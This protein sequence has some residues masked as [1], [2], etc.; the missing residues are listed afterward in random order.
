MKIAYN[1]A[2]A[3]KSFYSQRQDIEEKAKSGKM[4]KNGG[5]KNKTAAGL[6]LAASIAGAVI[7]LAVYN[8]RHGKLNKMK[9]VFTRSESTVKDKITVSSGIIDVEN[10]KQIGISVTG[11]ILG[12]LAAGFATDKNKENRKSKVQEGV[13][14]FLNCMIPMGIITAADTIIKR[15]EIKTGILGKTALIAGGI[16]SGMFLSNKVAN[17]VNKA[18]FNKGKEDGFEK[19]KMKPTDCLVHAD[20]VLGVLVMSKVPYVKEFGKLLPL[21]YSH[22]GYETGTKQKQEQ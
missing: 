15:K 6:T 13:Y 16:T 4:N 3:F 5:T 12:G 8:A 21:I 22:V 2:N 20:D 1:Q 14:G 11:S 19:R 17:G 18:V 10:I 7:P 9:D